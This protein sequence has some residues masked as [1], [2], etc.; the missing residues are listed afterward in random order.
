MIGLR[1]AT[2]LDRAMLEYW[3]TKAHVASATGS[4]GGSDWAVELG[5]DVDWCQSLIAEANGRPVAFVRIIDPAR[6]ETR[7]W[8]HKVEP[9]FRAIDIWIGE[10]ADLG[11]GY[12]TEIMR[13]VI[14][15][16]F[17]NRVVVAILIDPLAANA[18][19]IRFYQRL[20][21]QFVER[22]RFGNDECCVYRLD[23]ARWQGQAVNLVPGE[24]GQDQK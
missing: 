10:E 21:F 6:E 3:D 13:L 24:H 12:G 4:D 18:A 8:G 19:A 7:Y 20:G 15:R 5:R 14:E 2:P 11:R 22:R 23:R 1:R 16:C 9:G 17:D